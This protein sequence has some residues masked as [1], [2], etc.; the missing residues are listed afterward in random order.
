MNK[1]KI[2][3]AILAAALSCSANA[4]VAGAED[5]AASPKFEGLT[6]EQIDNSPI[7]PYVTLSSEVLTLEEAKAS[8]TRTITVTVNADGV[9]KPYYSAAGLHIYFDEALNVETSATGL[10]LIAKGEACSLM[11]SSFKVIPGDTSGTTGLFAAVAS[12]GNSGTNG[13]MFSFNVNLPS[14]IAAGDVF[15]FDIKYITT[16]YTKD[17][18]QAIGMADKDLMNGFTFTKGIYNKEYNPNFKA[19]E[20]DIERCPALKGISPSCDGYIAIEGDDTV[21]GD[22]DG[23]GALSVSDIVMVLQ[24][25]ANHD[26]YPLESDVLARCDVNGDNDVNV[27]DAALIQQADAGLVTLPVKK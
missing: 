5:T 19:S 15:P 7:K 9:T 21:W 27:E 2:I 8:P 1:R 25:A 3:S 18:F 6:L 17:I 14:D 22:A 20:S 12:S 11:A 13:T 23:N 10:P 26:K 4:V 16:E 24:Y